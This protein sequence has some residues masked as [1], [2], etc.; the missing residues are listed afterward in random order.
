MVK[1]TILQWLIVLFIGLIFCVKSYAQVNVDLVY[2]LKL[3]ESYDSNLNLT[4]DNE[5]SDWV[6]I[7]TPSVGLDL[8]SKYWE[9][10][11]KYSPSIYTYT[12]HKEYNYVAHDVSLD[13][14]YKIYRNLTFNMHNLFTMTQDL[15]S[16][17]GPTT[18]STVYTPS[19]YTIRKK[20]AYH[21]D[22]S[23]GMRL[24][25]Q[26]GKRDSLYIGYNHYR[27]WEEDKDIQEATRY[28]PVAGISIE[29]G[30]HMILSL[31]TSYIKGDFYGGSDDFDE[32]KGDLRLTK[33]ITKH[34]NVNIAYSH[35]YM[36]YSGDT[37]DYQIYAPSFGMAYRFSKDM[38]ISINTGF[39]KQDKER[40]RD[41]TGINLDVDFNKKW[42]IKKGSISFTYTSGYDE[43]YFGSENLGFT[44]YHGGRLSFIYDFTR[45]LSNSSYVDYRYNKYTDVD[46]DRKDNIITF[47]EALTYKVTKWMNIS[48][49][50]DYRWLDSNIDVNDYKD[51][52]VF[53]SIILYN[54]TKLVK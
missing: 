14:M 54:T 29:I 25:Y 5:Q 46:P 20:R 16:V 33:D 34:F 13:Y 44:I 22:Y 49:S 35:T 39:Y 6:N 2:S 3:S 51:H 11:L 31:D 17:T 7:I 15:Y 50:Y 41:E 47:N 27:N 24:N 23:G 18:S 12:D 19:E 37:E 36:D 28:N 10:N 38:S 53:F 42:R 48:I 8:T 1:R 32:L 52:R 40:G 30:P 43:T 4:R 45:H 9:A 26:F 21:S